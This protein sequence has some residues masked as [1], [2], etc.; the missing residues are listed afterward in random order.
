MD[1]P[2]QISLMREK[3]TLRDPAGDLSDEPPIVALSNRIVLNLVNQSER[4]TYVL[5]TQNMHSCVRLAAAIHKE[6]TER[7]SLVSRATEFRWDTLWSNVIKGYEKKYNPDIWAAVYENGEVVF[8]AGDHHPFLDIIEKCDSKQ[9]GDY[10]DSVSFAEKAFK[11]AG[12]TMKIEHD[13]NIALIGKITPEEAKCG[14]IIRGSNR[15]TTFNYTVNEHFRH[16]EPISIATIMSVSAAFLEGIQLAFHVG[17]GN[18]KMELELMEEYSEKYMQW[19]KTSS[20]LGSLNTAIS[21]FEMK[22]D[23]KYRPERP[24]FGEIVDDTE[25]FAAKLFK[26]QIE[27]KLQEEEGKEEELS[28]KN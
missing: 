8:A 27:E 12:K 9:K 26:P 15:T 19:K 11:Q 1:E 7:G 3:F 20:R 23:V 14:L 6:F 25:K 2:F 5:R 22:F 13:A 10:E 4:E 28:L 21:Q 24:S 17:M 16:K 18:K